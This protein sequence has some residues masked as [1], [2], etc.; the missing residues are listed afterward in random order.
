MGVFQGHSSYTP[1][2]RNMTCTRC[3][4][5]SDQDSENLLFP[6]D[7][8]EGGDRTGGLHLESVV[9]PLTRK[10]VTG[11]AG[12]QQDPVVPEEQQGPTGRP[13]AQPSC[14]GVGTAVASVRR[15]QIPKSETGRPS[16]EQCP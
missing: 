8:E 10:G 12:F 15:R 16:H 5:A 1:I 3:A 11:G 2:N 7:A 4:D 9:M 6:N 14:R 13:T